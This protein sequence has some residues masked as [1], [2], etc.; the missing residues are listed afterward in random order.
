MD[1][2]SKKR[3]GYHSQ[4]GRTQIGFLGTFPD[5]LKTL[6]RAIRSKNQGYGAK[7]IIA[8]LIH[9]YGYL[10]NDLPCKSILAAFLKEESFTKRYEPHSDL[11]ST[12]K[13]LKPPTRP[14]ERWQLDGRGNETV[15]GV[16]VVAL[17]SIKDVFSTLYVC[18]FPAVM[19]SLEGH[20]NT[21]DYQTALRIGFT[22]RGLPESLQ[23]DH[24]SVFYDN[25]TKSPFPTQLHLWLVALGVELIY[26][27]VHCP[28]D[29]GMVERSHET[30][31]NQVLKG[32][33]KFNS[34][35]HLYKKCRERLHY[36]NNFIESSSCD[37]KPPLVLCPKAIHSGK[38]Y[39]PY[40]EI[41]ILN[42][43]NVYKFLS[44]CKWYRNVASNKTVSLGGQVYYLANAT[45]KQQLEITFCPHCKYLMFHD[46]KELLIAMLPIKNINPNSLMGNLGDFTKINGLQ[47]PLVFDWDKQKITT[48]FSDL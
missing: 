36:L 40:E 12:I 3:G 10:E 11:P 19:K 31:Y 37:N 15:G 45:N 48:T 28:T 4:M 20:P 30:I 18:N 26:S 17:L 34:W 6:I 47:L 8:E 14:H 29:Q 33:V 42:M 1:S 9:K 2:S 41:S 32:Q 43:E 35:E 24:A 27:R 5:A 22:E 16:G 38:Y 25:K 39:N 21:S 13:L 44:E 46:D 7:S 23:V